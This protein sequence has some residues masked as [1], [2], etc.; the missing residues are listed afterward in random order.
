MSFLD[1][2]HYKV[3]NADL[4]L[5]VSNRNIRPVPHPGIELALVRTHFNSQRWIH[6]NKSD[7]D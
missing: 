2:S 6:T 7:S 1:I 3:N 4:I 5:N